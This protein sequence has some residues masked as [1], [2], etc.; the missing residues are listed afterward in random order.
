M[1]GGTIVSKQRAR[2]DHGAVLT[3]N[4]TSPKSNH[5]GPVLSGPNEGIRMGEDS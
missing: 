5:I 1:I 3:V 2:R 4:T